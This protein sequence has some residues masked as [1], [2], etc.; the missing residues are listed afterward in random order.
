MSRQNTRKNR[1][2]GEREIGGRR[3]NR[4]TEKFRHRKGE[5]GKDLERALRTY[6]ESTKCEQMCWKCEIDNWLLSKSEI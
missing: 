3:R 4:G 6:F 2:L 1:Y 5:R